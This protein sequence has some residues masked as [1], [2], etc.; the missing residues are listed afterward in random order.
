[1][2]RAIYAFTISLFSLLINVLLKINEYAINLS[3]S[4]WEL[5]QVRVRVE[6]SLSVTFLFWIE[7]IRNVICRQQN[8]AVAQE[9][10]TIIH[11][12]DAR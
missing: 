12:K 3:S 4:N 6:L 10:S 8:A 7:D 11:T 9:C 5:K 2:E 1:M